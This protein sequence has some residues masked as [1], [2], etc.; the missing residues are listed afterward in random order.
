MHGGRRYAKVVLDIRLRR[1]TSVNLRIVENEGQVLALFVS[2]C[3]SHVLLPSRLMLRPSA[4]PANPESYEMTPAP[5]PKDKYN[6]IAQCLL[7]DDR[8]A[9]AVSIAKY[10]P[11]RNQSVARV[12]GR[13][14]CSSSF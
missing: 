1:R 3:L 6:H 11:D 12:D 4:P 8:E 10:D 7:L 5:D 13:V 9:R 14:S 2:R